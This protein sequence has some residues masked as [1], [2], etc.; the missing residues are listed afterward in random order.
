VTG[1]SRCI[2]GI[3]PGLEGALAFF[4]PDRPERIAC[5]DMPCAAG[6]VDAVT[7]AACI[8]VMAPDEVFLEQVGAM[9]GQGVSSMFKFGRGFGTVIGVVGAL[10]IPL[11]LVAPTRWKAHFRLPADKE[12]ARALALRT[13]P[14]C[15]FQF[16][17]K[18]DHGR[19]EAALLARYGAEF[20][21][22]IGDV[23]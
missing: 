20:L 6:N 15:G 7:L 1:S 14:A 11:H 9:P 22:L 13:F 21:H 19:A 12:A 8:S 5:E 17:R 23:K 10:K 16:Q 3:D 18:K 4:F 2:L